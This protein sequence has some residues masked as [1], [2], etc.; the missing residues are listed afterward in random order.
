MSDYPSVAMPIM[1]VLHLGR[2]TLL[3]SAPI[4]DFL[5]EASYDPMC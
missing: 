4:P 2:L 3:F 1:T 5:K